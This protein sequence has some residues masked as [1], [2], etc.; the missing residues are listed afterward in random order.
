[1][2]S[3]R[4][5]VVDRAHLERAAPG[6]V[7]HAIASRALTGV[8]R[9]DPGAQI[10]G[11]T[12]RRSG[13]SFEDAIAAVNA[14]YDR[15]GEASIEKVNPPTDGWGPT[16]RIAGWATVD[17]VGSYRPFPR[18]DPD[19]TVPIAFDAKVI[20]DCA[21]FGLKS[22]PNTEGGRARRRLLSQVN[23]LIEKRARH[24]YRTFFL[25]YDE[26]IETAWVC[27]QLDTLSKGGSVPVRTKRRATKTRAMSIEHHLPHV[28]APLAR[29]AVP[30]G[31]TK[32]PLL[33]YLGLLTR[34]GEPHA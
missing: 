25:L 30:Q 15:T 12:A 34:A 5:A 26:A 28:V 4:P 22:V 2:K 31:A 16:L 24:G 19:Y 33:D 27:D 17:Y 14:W 3:A 20:T 18:S 7:L 11:T 32:R 6:S 29:A 10:G 1:M 13:R 8:A 9:K 23:H 21:S